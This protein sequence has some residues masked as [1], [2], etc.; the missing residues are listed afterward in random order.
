MS[1]HRYT[2]LRFACTRHRGDSSWG[3]TFGNGPIGPQDQTT[4]V[5]I[6]HVK[7]GTPFAHAGVHAGDCIVAVDGD[8]SAVASKD[9]FFGVLRRAALALPSSIQ[10]DVLRPEPE[11]HAARAPATPTSATTPVM[12][13]AHASSTS[14]RVVVDI[15]VHRSG[16]VLPAG[17]VSIRKTAQGNHATLNKGAALANVAKTNVYV[18]TLMAD[19]ERMAPDAPI[20]ESIAVFEQ[21]KQPVPYGHEPIMHTKGGKS[22]PDPTAP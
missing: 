12:P 7:P 17:W 22:C 4:V 14:E 18:C 15:G 5:R 2:R 19:L 21:G 6:S 20:V 16:E 13:T 10:L 3:V 9:N 1:H 8:A 11:P